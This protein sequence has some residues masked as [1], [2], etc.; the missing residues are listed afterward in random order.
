MLAIPALAHR[1]GDA[2]RVIEDGAVHDLIPL[3]RRK[4]RVRYRHH[5]PRRIR[6]H[7]HNSAPATYAGAPVSPAPARSLPKCTAA[8]LPGHILDRPGEHARPDSLLGA[9]VVPHPARADSARPGHGDHNPAFLTRRLR[10]AEL[11]CAGRCE[12]DPAA[13]KL[14]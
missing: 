4:A 9:L 3:A 11:T 2:D 10:P 5:I 7:N 1:R 8:I 12:H 6:D 14:S 13:R